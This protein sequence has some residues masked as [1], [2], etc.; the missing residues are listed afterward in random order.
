MQSGHDI[1]AGANA[2]GV[3]VTFEGGDGCGKTTHI[4]ILAK[5]LTV[6][7]C[8]VVCVREPGGTTIG[9]E[10]RSIVLD[11]DNDGLSTRAELL[12]YEAARAQLVDEVIVPA[13]KRGA[14]VLCDRFTD[15]TMAYQGYARFL[16]ADFV[17]RCSAFA[18]NG[19][20]PDAT[21]LLECTDPVVREERI[22][23]R[24]DRDRLEGEGALFHRMVD[25]AFRK[26]ASS[27]PG[28]V[29]VVPTSGSKAATAAC[30]FV[31]LMDVLPCLTDVTLDDLDFADEIFADEASAD[32]SAAAK[33]AASV[34]SPEASAG[35]D[36]QD[37]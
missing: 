21:I 35:D 7:G 34:G 13:L 23:Q 30:V 37:G 14:V 22:L 28:R 15:S 1:K 31:S 24:G 3:L 8:D 32:A 20:E 25:A 10:L 29:R 16:D 36:G 27:A 9:E 2:P 6:L 26:I 18:A 4:T 5:M 17:E 19:L 12:I 11:R 33:E